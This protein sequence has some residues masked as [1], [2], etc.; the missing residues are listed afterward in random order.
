MP[1]ALVNVH[2]RTPV[3]AFLAYIGT[4]SV[5]SSRQGHVGVC[6]CLVVAA[7]QTLVVAADSE[8]WASSSLC[9]VL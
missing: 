7:T 1:V 8:L 2:S 4:A 3:N 9:C 6:V 5:I